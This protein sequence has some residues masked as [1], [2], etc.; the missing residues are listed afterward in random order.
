MKSIADIYFYNAMGLAAELKDG[1]VSEFRALKH[2]IASII[3]GGIG[4]DVPVSVNLKEAASGFWHSIGYLAV[5]IIT[6]IIS[7]YGVLL[8]YQVNSKGDGKDYFLRFSALALP[9]G[10]QLVILFLGIGLLL[11][12]LTAALTSQF[13]MSG[14]YFAEVGF[15]LATIAF[16]AM[17]FL[18]MRKYIGVA[19]G[20]E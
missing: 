19:A 3:L 4:F 6:G 12:L 16:T 18:R 14:A 17:F 15:Y 5:F 8:T 20:A 7:Y 10:I 2:L 13:G 1:T 11:V 9:V